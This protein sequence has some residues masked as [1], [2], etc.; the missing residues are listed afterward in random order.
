MTDEAMGMTAL[1]IPELPSTADL[2]TVDI[3]PAARDH[4][5]SFEAT[6][7][8]L[9]IHEGGHLVAL[10]A[11]GIKTKAV[12]ITSRHGGFTSIVGPES[13]TGL[14]WE[15]AGRMRQQM[16][17]L[18]AGSAAERLLLNDVTDGGS[19]DLD[20][21]VAAG[22]RYIKAGFSPGQFVGEDGLAYGYL[23][24]EIKTRILLRIQELVAEA[25]ATAEAL[26]AQH[27]D[28]LIFIATAVYEKRRLS[29]ER[30]D[31]VLVA[32]GFTLPRATA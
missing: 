17:A 18:A 15:T 11:Q 14:P 10:A 25:Q 23:T 2:I 29:D 26:V 8:L 3:R 24:D 28:A 13:D 6:Q 9:A 22:H 12:D 4:L 32:A 31:E 27:Q 5:L 16:A 21:I 7:R 19:T 20:A 1:M 30:L